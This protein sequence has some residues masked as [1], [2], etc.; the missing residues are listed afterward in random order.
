MK[1][2][3]RIYRIF[4]GL[5][6]IAFFVVATATL[7]GI[8]KFFGKAVRSPLGLITL[9]IFFW[10]RYRAVREEKWPPKWTPLLAVAR[11]CECLA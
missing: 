6:L 8:L 7:N 3:F 2:A 4:Y 10:L 11:A 1:R 5:L 9:A